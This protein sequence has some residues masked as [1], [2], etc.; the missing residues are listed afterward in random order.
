MEGAPPTETDEFIAWAKN[1]RIMRRVGYV[2]IITAGINKIAGRIIDLLKCAVRRDL[3][4]GDIKVWVDY[5]AR[6]FP[7]NPIAF[8]PVAT[9][10]PC[11]PA[12]PARPYALSLAV[13]CSRY[14]YKDVCVRM[15]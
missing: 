13:R 14:A 4:P 2:I 3:C 8:P 6:I 15:K 5:R 10:R 7:D 9:D 11:L 12:T 1:I